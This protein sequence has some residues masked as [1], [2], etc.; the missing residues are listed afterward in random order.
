[1]LSWA[2]FKFA[3]TYKQSKVSKKAWCHL[4]PWIMGKSKAFGVSSFSFSDSDFIVSG[5]PYD[6]CHFSWDPC[7]VR[8]RIEEITSR[9]LFK[10][11]F[12]T[13]SK[14]HGRFHIPTL[15]GILSLS[16]HQPFCFQ[17]NK[18]IVE[19]A[20]HFWN[21]NSSFGLTVDDS[22][23]QH[24]F[25]ISLFIIVVLNLRKKIICMFIIAFCEG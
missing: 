7:Q 16:L 21:R 17:T 25:F 5:M 13:L 2:I 3:A 18:G 12:V 22:K 9:A 24:W 19:V 14:E 1:M 4:F 20:N 15:L 8:R 6:A 10:S 11:S 23:T